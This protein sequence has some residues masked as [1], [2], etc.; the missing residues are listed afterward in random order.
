M[1]LSKLKR[2]L[3]SRP[4]E[5]VTTRSA[6]MVLAQADEK[7]ALALAKRDAGQRLTRAERMLLAAEDAGMT[8]EHQMET[9]KRVSKNPERHSMAQVSAVNAAAS[10]VG[11]DAGTSAKEITVNVAVGALWQLA[12]P[13]ADGSEGVQEIPA[14]GCTAD[15]TQVD[16]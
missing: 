3:R 9:L 15:P 1:G 8:P 16:D 2:L 12:T 7:V 14:L 5:V 13:N 11:D 10:L 4:S 6:E